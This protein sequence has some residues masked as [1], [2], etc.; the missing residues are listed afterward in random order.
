MIRSLIGRVAVLVFGITCVASSLRAER[1]G[2]HFIGALNSFGIGGTTT[3][4]GTSG[5]PKNAPISG[6]FSYDTTTPG[7]DVTTDT[8]AGERTYHQYISGGFTLDINPG[9]SPEI[10]L[11][12][13]DY[14]ITVV[15]DF[16]SQ[17]AP[18]ALDVFDV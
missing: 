14:I 12:A 18:E 16:Q 15:N 4:F 6:T 8:A 1:V 9:N 5:I 3:L 7:V 2:Y 13:S 11:S 17:T 10:K